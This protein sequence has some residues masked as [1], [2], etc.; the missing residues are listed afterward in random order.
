MSL[1]RG[2]I[3]VDV[4]FWGGLVDDNFK[5]IEKMIQSGVIG[6]QCSLIS[7]DDFPAASKED[8]EKVLPL[9]D[10]NILAVTHLSS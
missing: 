5:E 8:I 1:A 4:G 10:D 9:L 2:K 6:I 3:Y 7:M